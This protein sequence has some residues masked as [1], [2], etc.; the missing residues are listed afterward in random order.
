M[1]SK[2]RKTVWLTFTSASLFSTS[3]SPSVQ[4]ALFHIVDIAVKLSNAH[5]RQTCLFL[6]LW[7]ILR[8]WGG[9]VGVA[10]ICLQYLFTSAKKQRSSGRIETGRHWV[11]SLRVPSAVPAEAAAAAA[12]GSC[13]TAP[14]PVWTLWQAHINR[15]AIKLELEPH[16]HS[17]H[18]SCSPLRCVALFLPCFDRVFVL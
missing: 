11:S 5:E 6:I 18:T 9:G 15:Y 13:G 12:A 7:L 4:P 10:L 14:L 16:F 17:G 8:G 2:W 1:C 3:P